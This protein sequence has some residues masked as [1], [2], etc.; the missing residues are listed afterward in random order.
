MS[1][2]YQRLIKLTFFL[3]VVNNFLQSPISNLFPQVCLDFLRLEKKLHRWSKNTLADQRGA[4]GT[5]AP[6]GVQILSFSCSFQQ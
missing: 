5:R 6:P 4:P 3:T 2:V 1:S